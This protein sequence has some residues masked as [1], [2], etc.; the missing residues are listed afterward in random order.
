MGY[1]LK[2]ELL[3]IKLGYR[4]IFIN[5]NFDLSKLFIC[6]FEVFYVFN[7]ILNVLLVYCVELIYIL[8]MSVIFVRRYF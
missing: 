6:R 2:N 5:I 8:L 1:C 7:F 3:G 4:F